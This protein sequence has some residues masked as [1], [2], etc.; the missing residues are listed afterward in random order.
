MFL[1]IDIIA[2]MLALFVVACGGGD[3][4][5]EDS[6]V[7]AIVDATPPLTIGEICELLAPSS[8]ERDAECLQ[9]LPPPCEESLIERCC[10]QSG[11]C[12]LVN[13][14]TH[15]R[16]QECIAAIYEAT[17]AE[18]EEGVPPPCTRISNPDGQWDAGVEAGS[19]VWN[20]FDL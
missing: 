1:R 3:G 5:Q 16:V 18:L 7:G 15:E 11:T 17:C 13:G 6:G 8:C 2:S 12:A 10:G 20:G 4:E 19:G 14:V 9:S